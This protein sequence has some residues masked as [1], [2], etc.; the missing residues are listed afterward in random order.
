MNRLMTTKAIGSMSVLCVMIVAL[1]AFTIDGGEGN[2]DTVIGQY[3]VTK[4]AIG[5]ILAPSPSASVSA[6]DIAKDM[7]DEALEQ[8]SEYDESPDEGSNAKVFDE[9]SPAEFDATRKMAILPRTLSSPYNDVKLDGSKQYFLY[10]PSGGFNNQI[11]CFLA[12]ISVARENNY[13]LIV[14]PGGKHSNFE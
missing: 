7:N 4:V 11:L 14:P 10:S 2:M 9:F 6:E 3:G 5:S 12:A 13:T 8:E 1:I